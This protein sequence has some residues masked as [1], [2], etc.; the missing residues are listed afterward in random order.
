MSDEFDDAVDPIATPAATAVAATAPR[1]VG[2]GRAAR[3]M[4]RLYGSANLA[5][6]TRLIACLLR[7]LGSL[8][9]AA[10]AA[11]AFTVV[12]S[13]RGAGGFGV[14]IADV[15][16]FSKDQVAEL[17]R[18]V[19]QV[20]PEALQQAAGMVFENRFGVGAFTASVALLL[21]LE[22][23]RASAGDRRRAPPNQAAGA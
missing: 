17:A 6:R 5:L 20:S 22:L 8:G 2:S 19:E 15:A 18:F 14:A 16:D 21:A 7:P 3:L 23:R 4:A 9:V 12:V 1:G 11:G 13:R 10:V